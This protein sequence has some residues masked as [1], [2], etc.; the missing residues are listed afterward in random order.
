MISKRQSP[1]YASACYVL[2]SG[3][4]VLVLNCPTQIRVS[5]QNQMNSVPKDLWPEPFN[6]SINSLALAGFSLFCYFK[7][8][9]PPMLPLPLP[10][11]PR[12]SLHF[13][14]SSLVPIA[15]IVPNFNFPVRGP[16]TSPSIVFPVLELAYLPLLFFPQISFFLNLLF[17]LPLWFFPSSRS[18]LF[19]GSIE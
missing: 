16:L 17:L 19:H 9:P 10:R 8:L 4:K 6:I 3:N 12:L 1:R 11:V 18:F 15:I 14:Q 7:L 13:R 2:P 5:W